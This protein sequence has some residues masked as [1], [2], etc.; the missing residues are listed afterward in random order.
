MSGEALAASLSAEKPDRVRRRKRGPTRLGT[1]GI[2]MIVPLAVL[3]LWQVS[4]SFDILPEQILPPPQAVI[5]VLQDSWNDG[6]L[7][8]NTL[9]SL[10]RVVEGF[11]AGAASGLIV[12]VAFGLSP[13]LRG[14]CEP[15]FLSLSQVPILGWLP[16]LILVAG[17]G[18]TPKIIAIGWSGFVPVVLNASQGIRDVPKNFIE[19]GRVLNFGRWSMLSTI[20]LPSAVPQIFSGLREGIANGWQTLVAVELL[21]SFSGL[22]YMMAY[23]RQLFQ[24]EMVLAAVIIVGAIGLALHLLLAVAERRLLRWRTGTA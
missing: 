21:G 11:G 1:I 18:D 3:A 6:S 2:G 22:G 17:L 13:R 20:I 16:I 8:M 10:G 4:A 24:L 19:L 7:Q 9:V 5:G 12:G 23:G 14:F 15:L